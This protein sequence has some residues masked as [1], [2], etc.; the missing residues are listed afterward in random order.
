MISKNAAC[1]SSGVPQRQLFLHEE[2]KPEGW[3]SSRVGWENWL[4]M[5]WR[6]TG[7]QGREGRWWLRTR[8]I[9]ARDLA[10]VCFGNCKRRIQ[11]SAKT[12]S[13]SYQEEHSLPLRSFS[14]AFVGFA[15]LV[16]T[17]WFPSSSFCFSALF[18]LGVILLHQGKWMYLPFRDLFWDTIKICSLT[19]G[20]CCTYKA[21]VWVD[22]RGKN[23]IMHWWA[24]VAERAKLQ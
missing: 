1:A 23:V 18:P 6:S 12:R 8:G 16:D 4:L 14:P 19:L 24:S 10:V 22:R 17:F 11:C 2:L 9:K 7:R 20:S 13:D 15:L 5:N 21:L 3:V